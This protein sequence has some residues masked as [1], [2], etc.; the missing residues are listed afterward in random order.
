MSGMGELHLEIV[1]N[2]IVSEK[3][4]KVK[5]SQPI[6]VYRESITKESPEVEGKSPNKHNKFYII[7]EP[8]PDAIKELLSSG[9]IPSGQ[10][11]KKSDE[12]WKKLIDAGM[13]RDVA[14]RVKEIYNNSIFME[15]TKGIVHIGEVLELCLEAFRD[16]MKRGPLARE[17][18]FGVIVNLVDCSLHEDAIHRGPAQV[19]PA[20]RDAI[21]EAMINAG[22]VIFEPVQT[23]RFDAPYEYMGE[24]S[25]I[26]QSRRGQLLEVSQEELNM[27][28]KAK[29]PVAEMFGLADVLRSGTEGRGS[30]SLQDSQF[31][32]LPSSLQ[33]TVVK[34]IRDRKGLAPEQR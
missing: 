20:V 14:K 10:L 27:T 9:A 4:V 12:I 32:R 24:V 34:R 28:A 22:P 30:W 25:K 33:D 21:K 1:E 8:V 31:E 3:N 16:V 2:R 23:I 18:C 6:V 29:M 26:V 7:V 17:P 13:E 5:T 19:I 11:K 15:T